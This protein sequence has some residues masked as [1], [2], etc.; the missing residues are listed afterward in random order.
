MLIRI[1]SKHWTLSDEILDESAFGQ[2]PI[3]RLII[4]SKWGNELDARSQQ[5]WTQTREK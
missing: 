5:S 4:I 2:K 1:K 3:F